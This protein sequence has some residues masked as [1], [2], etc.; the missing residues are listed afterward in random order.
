MIRAVVTGGTGF[1]GRKLTNALIARGWQVTVLTRDAEWA[2]TRLHASARVAGWNSSASGPW[3]DEIDGVD[4]VVNL[5][6]E[7]VFDQPWTKERLAEL[8]SSR[9]D[10]TLGLAT[11][12]AK[13]KKKPKL[14]VSASAVGIYGMRKDDTVLGEDA[15][16]GDDA[17]ADICR[18]WEKAADPAREAGIRVAH[19]RIGVVLGADGGALGK[20][21]PAFKWHVGGPLGDGK[22]WVSWVHWRDVVDAVSFAYEKA[23]LVGPFNLVSP[24]PVTMNDF[25]HAIGLV[26]NRGARVHVPEFAVRLAVGEGAAE[27]LLTGQRAVPRKLEGFGFGFSYPDV[28]AALEE[29]IGPK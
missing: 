10:V 4:V 8:R 15:P 16:L 3:T 12:L 29:L 18:A 19:P 2:R 22:Q 9:V 27:V 26:L 1:I 11:A 28:V 20:M 21:L 17:L 23:E 7:G 5:A 14:L 24:N 6:G 13:A 25:A